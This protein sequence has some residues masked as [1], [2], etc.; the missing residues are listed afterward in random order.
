MKKLVNGE[1]VEMTLAEIQK[2]ELSRRQ[3]W[4][5]ESHIAEINAL[6]EAE[7][8]RRL[9]AADYVAE[10][11]LNAVLADSENEYFDEA[12]LIINYWWNGWDA[13]KAYSETVTEQNMID[14]IQFVNNLENGSY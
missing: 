4:N 3:V 6:H 12:V 9:L 10:W 14:P 8:K 13:I 2:L 5:K 11:E 1:E 7:F